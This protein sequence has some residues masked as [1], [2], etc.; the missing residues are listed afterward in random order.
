VTE[1]QENLEVPKGQE[2]NVIDH[3]IADDEFDKAFQEVFGLPSGVVK[4]LGEV[5]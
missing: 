5:S 4:S 3:F 1:I 2:E